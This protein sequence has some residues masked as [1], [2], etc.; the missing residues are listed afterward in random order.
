MIDKMVS[1]EQGLKQTLAQFVGKGEA[2]GCDIKFNDAENTISLENFK[3]D[4]I[5]KKVYEF[6]NEMF[7]GDF[8]KNLM[9]QMMN[10]F[11]NMGDLED[12]MK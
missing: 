10:A 3:D 9:E 2:V 4:K 11:K 5:A 8:L 7:F 6:F 12:I 1:D